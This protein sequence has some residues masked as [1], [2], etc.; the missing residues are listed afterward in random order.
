MTD[1]PDSV[2]IARKITYE[3][4]APD[5]F[6][7]KYLVFT[8]EGLGWTAPAYAPYL[9]TLIIGEYLAASLVVHCVDLG[10]RIKLLPNMKRLAESKKLTEHERSILAST[11]PWLLP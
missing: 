10:K 2:D 9:D 11:E 8:E 4:N 3:P 5:N 1:H 7:P 6:H